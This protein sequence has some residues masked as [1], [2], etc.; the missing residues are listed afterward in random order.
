MPSDDVTLHIGADATD[1]L[2]TVDKVNKEFDKLDGKKV[3]PEIQ[4]KDTIAQFKA[5]VAEANKL[6]VA[7]RALQDEMDGALDPESAAKWVEILAKGGTSL[8]VITQHAGVAANEL[9]QLSSETGTALTSMVGPARAG[10][11]ELKAGFEEA[12]ATVARVLGDTTGQLLDMG[13]VAE[14]VSMPIAQLAESLSSLLL[15]KE[16]GGSA[17]AITGLLKAAGPIAAITAGVGLAT[18]A[19]ESYKHKQEEIAKQTEATSKA[20]VEMIPGLD[21]VNKKIEELGKEPGATFGDQL[22]ASLNQSDEAF[23]S[24]LGD[25]NELGISF[26]QL[27]DILA[28]FGAKGTGNFDSL[29]ANMQANLHVTREEAVGIAEALSRAGGSFEGFIASLGPATGKVLTWDQLHNQALQDQLRLYFNIRSVTESDD[30]AKNAK[31]ALDATRKTTEGLKAYKQ[32]KEDLAKQGIT[33]PSDIVLLTKTDEILGKILDKT[34]DIVAFR[35]KNKP[36]EDEAAIWERVGKQAENV[37][38]KGQSFAAVQADINR[39]VKDYGLTED[40]VKQKALDRYHDEANAA[41]DAAQKKADAAKAALQA[42]IE[43]SRAAAQAHDQFIADKRAESVAILDVERALGELGGAF[44]QLK[45]GEDALSSAFDVKD[46]PLKFLEDITNIH[47]GMRDLAKF[48]KDPKGLKG[49]IPNIFDPNDLHAGEFLSKIKSLR[50]PIQQE[51]TDAF[52]T[53]GADAA[54]ATADDFVNQLFHALGGKLS[55]GQIEALLG[56]TDLQ[57]TIKVA[58]DQQSKATAEKEL[59]LFTQLRGGETPFTATLALALESGKL[60]PGA[61]QN[62]LRQQFAKIPG[63]DISV[64]PKTND[65]DSANAVREAQTFMSDPAHQVDMVSVVGVPTNIAEQ[66]R[67]VNTLLSQDEL[68]WP[69]ELALAPNAIAD[70]QKQIAAAQLRQKVSDFFKFFDAG[71]SVP[72]RGFGIAGER[73]PEII[74]ERYLVTEPTLVPAGTRV[75]SGARTARILRARGIRGLRR[76]DAGGTV[77]SSTNV[78]TINVNAAVVGNRYDVMRAVRRAELDRQR[79]LGTRS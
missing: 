78:T 5:T 32:A 62:I 46:A 1:A 72:R 74:N 73:R 55:K 67:N 66:H 15:R 53:G 47:D 40:Q 75:T 20:L 19:W 14:Q 76:Y 21:D 54:T 34:G 38:Q 27:G 61:L 24:V 10:S 11:D 33:D 69:V 49:N 37:V 56:L 30:V 12:H 60:S 35:Q 59:E 28:S 29:V 52:A 4:I 17:A 43:S 41:V 45:L 71:G 16:G 48:I 64:L 77:A 7:A 44:G 23:G 26:S 58:V 39:L 9:K 36:L 22:V 3:S 68:S 70:M 65:A 31:S 79:L 63:F 2:R 51:I 25:A 57:A 18:A 42:E 8:E 50:G 13:G 6:A